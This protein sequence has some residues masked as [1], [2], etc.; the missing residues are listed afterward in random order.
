MDKN[1]EAD[2]GNEGDS[3]AGWPPRFDSS[4][5]GWSAVVLLAVF[6]SVSG[7]FRTVW[8]AGGLFAGPQAPKHTLAY[9]LVIV[10][11]LCILAAL[12]FALIEAKTPPS[13][14]APP[15]E[16][17]IRELD[18]QVTPIDMVASMAE[19]LSTAK[20]STALLSVGFVLLLLAATGTGMISLSIGDTT[21]AA[22]SPTAT[23]TTTQ[24]RGG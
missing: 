18:R 14:A 23:P 8:E 21:P 4:F 10:G 15:D 16:D 19:A 24:E 6:L 12:L 1:G 20:R 13:S 17:K 22:P 2:G 7:W 9:V 11:L 5:I 3:E